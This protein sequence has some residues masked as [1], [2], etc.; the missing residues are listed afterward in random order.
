MRA[1]LISLAE[2]PHLLLHPCAVPCRLDDPSSAQAQPHQGGPESQG[3]A[4][5]SAS[6]TDVRASA[7][8]AGASPADARAS[9]AAD[10]GVQEAGVYEEGGAQVAGAYGEGGAQGLG[11]PWGQDLGQD[12]L[13]RDAQFG[14]VSD[15]GSEGYTTDEM[16]SEGGGEL[17]N[18]G[19]PYGYGDGYG[20]FGQQGEGFG[21]G[22][23]DW[24][25]YLD[26]DELDEGAEGWGG[27]FE[28]PEMDGMLDDML[29]DLIMPEP[30]DMPAPD[31]YL[32]E[33]HTGMPTHPPSSLL[34]WW[35]HQKAS[36]LT[37]KTPTFM[38]HARTL[39]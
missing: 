39:P 35:D 9:A 22:E 36:S 12:A 17:L 18:D 15:E 13:G 31:L 38:K 16:L 32:G 3:T 27:G 20:E 23:Q 11:N 28:D 10:S 30:P 7:A 37:P 5:A 2:N 14:D 1:H 8:D 19:D 25:R 4:G 34:L 26:D 24:G 21:G 29:G 33:L 6:P